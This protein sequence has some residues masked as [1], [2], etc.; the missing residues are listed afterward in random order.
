MTSIELAQNENFQAIAVIEAVKLLAEKNGVDSIDL[1]KEFVS[2]VNESLMT[3]VA[4]MVAFA[5]KQT[6]AAL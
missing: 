2:G 4:E 3:C 6:A 1:M 5:A